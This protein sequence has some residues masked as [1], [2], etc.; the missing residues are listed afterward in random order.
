MGLI[1]GIGIPL[2]RFIVGVHSLDQI[3]YGC[4]LG[5]WGGLV[6]HYVVRVPLIIHISCVIKMERSYLTAM[7]QIGRGSFRLS[8]VDSRMNGQ[9]GLTSLD[10]RR[11]DE[12]ENDLLQGHNDMIQMQQHPKYLQ[13]NEDE[14]VEPS[15]MEEDADA[16]QILRN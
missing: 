1:W 12:F 13:F 10:S 9:L 2:S 16:D 4:S 14:E 6:L 3:I 7:S 15:L 5:I 8:S 11:D